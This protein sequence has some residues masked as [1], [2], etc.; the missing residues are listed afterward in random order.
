MSF[1]AETATREHL[2]RHHR[3]MVALLASLF[4]SD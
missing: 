4:T 3:S 1:D 2:G